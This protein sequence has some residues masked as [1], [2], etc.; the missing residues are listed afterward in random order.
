MFVEQT[1]GNVDI[2]KILLKVWRVFF[3]AYWHP[4]VVWVYLALTGLGIQNWYFNTG[5]RW[6]A[7]SPYIAWGI[8]FDLIALPVVVLYFMPL[9]LVVYILFE[10]V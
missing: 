4:W 3:I 1:G 9:I 2:K 7:R 8:L 5:V 6:K 10:V